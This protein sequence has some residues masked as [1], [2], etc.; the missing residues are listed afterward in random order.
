[1]RWHRL[2]AEQ[3][4]ANAQFNLGVMHATGEG[5]LKD[6]VL[7]HMWYNDQALNPAPGSA[8][9]SLTVPHLCVW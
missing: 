8:G 3:G 6:S 1:M 4:N 5:V 7:V 9:A 2:A